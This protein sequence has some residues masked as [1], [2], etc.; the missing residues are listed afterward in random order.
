MDL[1]KSGELDY[2]LSDNYKNSINS[3][4]LLFKQ[5]EHSFLSFSKDQEMIVIES[6]QDNT[7]W[8]YLTP[9]EASQLYDWLHNNTVR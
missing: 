4:K 1:D 9:K 6:F 2:K 5:F 8:H 7:N 3:D